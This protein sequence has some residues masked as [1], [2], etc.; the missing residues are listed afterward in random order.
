MHTLDWSIVVVFMLVITAAAFY[1]RNY[2]RSVADFLAAN[3]CAGRY[4]LTAADGM[5]AFGLTSIIMFFEMYYQAGFSAQWWQLGLSPIILFVYLSGWVVYRY[6]RTR[7]MT[8]LQ[9]FEQRYSKS[10][11]VFVG[12]L[13]FWVFLITMGIMPGTG[14]RF[15]I[16]ACNLPDAF[17]VLGVELQTFPVVML[18]LL[19]TG[20]LFTFLGGHIAVMVTDF[21]QGMF[22]N[23]VLLVLVVLIMLIIPWN[24][25]VEGLSMAPDDA[26]MVHP[27]RTEQ[28]QTYD[29][30]FFVIWG[31]NFLYMF[32]AWQGVQAYNSAARTPH[33]ARMARVLG[34]IRGIV[35]YN[36]VIILPI[37]AFVLMH[38]PDYESIAQAVQQ[39]ISTLSGYYG[40]QVTV[41]IAISKIIPMGFF[42]LFIAAMLGAM[43]STIDTLLHAWGSIFVQDIVLPFRKKPFG[44][45]T[46]ML[47]LRLAI[48][49]VAVFLFLFSMLYRQK[50]DI[51]L[52][53]AI[54]GSFYYGGA[55]AALVCGLYWKGGTTAGA[56]AGMLTGIV[57]TAA[58][59]VLQRFELAGLPDSQRL[60]FIIMLA[61]LT[62][63]IG[64][65][66]L[67]TRLRWAKAC[68]FDK[69]FHRGKY[70]T[71]REEPPQTTRQMNRLE[72][73]LGITSDFTG[74]DRF[75][76]YAIL[77]NS[78]IMIVVFIVITLL[79]LAHDFD[80]SFWFNVWLV[81]IWNTIITGSVVTVWFLIGGFLDLGSLFQRLS[82][83][84]RNDLDD[85]MVVGQQNLDD[86]GELADS[87]QKEQERSGN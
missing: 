45:R 20:L 43:I 16:Y 36:A 5:V 59:F 63:Y 50:Q 47:L 33:E 21:L 56:W 26:S 62:A 35:L 78:L 12:F 2:T 83:K 3:R 73:L 10:F 8:L 28:T 46:H 75:V 49:G 27:L 57:L 69:L 32:P 4:L 61:S 11:R 64:M 14:A 80:E 55:G 1:T 31:F 74:R 9:F 68:D 52:F 29:F 53:W 34:N 60:S 86:A 70:E 41:P 6:R 44:R 48:F 81:Y 72:K 42:G 15:F 19:G 37:A 82:G 66:L 54:V 30:W 13:S 85:G 67:S 38:H 76:Y 77:I 23:I 84:Q 87:L 22:C 79:N 17:V 40:K 25:V 51:W 7:S 39:R 65:S 71:R 58:A 18:F 24:T